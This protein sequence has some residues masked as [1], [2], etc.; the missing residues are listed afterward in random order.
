MKTLIFAIT[1]FLK[2]ST[3]HLHIP[4]NLGPVRRGLL[5]PNMIRRIQVFV[6]KKS[7]GEFQIIEINQW[8]EESL[9]PEIKIKRKLD[10]PRG[11]YKPDK[12]SQMSRD[13]KSEVVKARSR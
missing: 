11:F 13:R 9:K 3:C 12:R 5:I 2:L 7:S 6:S 8:E 4:Q 1:S 10:G